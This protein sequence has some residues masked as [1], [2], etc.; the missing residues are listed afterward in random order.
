MSAEDSLEEDDGLLGGH[1][2]KDAHE[3]SQASHL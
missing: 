1:L 2:E 3:W